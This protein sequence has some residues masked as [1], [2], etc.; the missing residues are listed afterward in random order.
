[1]GYS[2]PATLPA[3][4]RTLA[5]RGLMLDFLIVSTSTA[6]KEDAQ[7]IAQ[8]VLEPHLAACVQ[9]VGPVSSSYWWQ[10]KLETS[11]EW[12]CLI[13]T[14]MAHYPE[15]EQAVLAAHKYEVPEL[16]AVPIEAGSAAY[17]KW[18]GQELS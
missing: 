4:D 2:A 13:K 1:M 9:V 15:L 10:G 14:S 16:V 7:R 6:T 11:E 12:L 18:L 3:D 17:L 5:P 8:A